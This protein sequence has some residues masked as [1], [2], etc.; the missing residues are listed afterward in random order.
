LWNRNISFGADYDI[1]VP[2]TAPVE[3]RNRF[4]Q[5]STEGLHAGAVIINANGRV[6]LSS[7]RGRQRIENRF[8]EVEVRSN[9]GDVTVRNANG[10]VVATDI[11]GTLKIS[12]GFGEVRS[13]MP[14]V[15][16]R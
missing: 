7:G 4:G 1:V 8:G 14:R 6:S 16:R 10:R 11:R 15:V 5:V 13:V 2:E 9:D 12:D 3:V